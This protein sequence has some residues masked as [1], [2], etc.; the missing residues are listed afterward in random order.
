MVT[1]PEIADQIRQPLVDNI[2]QQNCN[3][4]VTTNPGCQLHLQQGFNAKNTHM[5]VIHPITLLAQQ[6]EA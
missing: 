2:T 6:L 4:V 5:Q 1:H 3:L